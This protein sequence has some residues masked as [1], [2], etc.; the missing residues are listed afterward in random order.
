MPFI[1][2]IFFIIGV[3]VLIFASAI[4]DT[5]NISH[6][7]SIIFAIAIIV[8][9]VIFQDNF[10]A[11][12][13]IAILGFFAL[14]GIVSLARY[15]S[16]CTVRVVISFA[17]ACL[18]TIPVFIS[19]AYSINPWS[20]SDTHKLIEGADYT[21]TSYVGEIRHR[22]EITSEYWKRF[23]EC[24]GDLGFLYSTDEYF[25]PYG[26]KNKYELRASLYYSD[27]K[28]SINIAAYLVPFL[29]TT[30]ESVSI[31]FSYNYVDKVF[32]KQE[33]S[34]DVKQFLQNEISVRLEENG[35]N[36]FNKA[37]SGH[38]I[39]VFKAIKKT[40]WENY[41]K[42]I[43]GIRN[44]SLICL[45]VSVPSLIS[46]FVVFLCLC[47]KDK[48]RLKPIPKKTKIKLY[49][50]NFIKKDEH[51]VTYSYTGLRNYDIKSLTYETDINVNALA[52]CKIAIITGHRDY[53]PIG[54]TQI[55]I[56]KLSTVAQEKYQNIVFVKA[57]SLLPC[58]CIET[59][60]LVLGDGSLMIPLLAESPISMY[61]GPEEFL[62]SLFKGIDEIVHL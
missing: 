17:I 2:L 41:K 35:F 24:S 50:A 14:I 43:D 20:I 3:I 19:S 51:T 36:L 15:L 29:G 18:L 25:Y 62:T 60:A 52:N 13:L 7:L 53:M 8:L 23:Y 46:G 57:N 49:K 27:Q 28:D 54:N 5:F 21:E 26:D 10:A 48:D 58:N 16:R 59:I 22:A 42:E 30:S 1:A 45:A 56:L 4:K 33:T 6:G 12:V 55:N 37:L 40:T 11:V 38:R 34:D 31:F 44:A 39:D 47:R 61:S 9:I 32:M